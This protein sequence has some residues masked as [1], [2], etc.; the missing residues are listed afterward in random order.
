MK[1]IMFVIVLLALALGGT[2]VDATKANAAPTVVCDPNG[3]GG[4]GVSSLQCDPSHNWQAVVHMFGPFYGTRNYRCNST[5]PGVC[6]WDATIGAYWWFYSPLYSQ[7]C[8][9]WVP[10]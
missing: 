9:G 6:Y 3:C 5:A 7:Q 8:Y 2:S 4:G 10:A 1:R